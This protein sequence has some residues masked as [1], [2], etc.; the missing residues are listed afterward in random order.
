MFATLAEIKALLGIS[1]T[2]Y[3]TR[4]TALIPMVEI[5]LLEE[6]NNTFT[7]KAISFGGICTITS[8]GSVY[9][10][11]C[12]DGKIDEADFATGDWIWLTG[13]MR[14]DGYYS[15]KSIAAGYIEVN[16]VLTAQADTSTMSL[17]LIDIPSAIKIYFAKMVAWQ[18]YH[19]K[20][21]GLQSESIGNYSYS[22]SALA[23]DAGYPSTL[24]GGLAK[25]KNISLRRGSVF[26]QI[27]DRRGMA[28]GNYA[29]SDMTDL[30]KEVA[31]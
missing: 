27:R 30:Y 17:T 11:N 16:E 1:D 23:S 14:N 29:D 18:L 24:L 15:I 7:N 2:T 28:I 12:A 13:S 25:W 8:A 31:R 19:V 20:D 9:K 3:D 5:D 10:I 26:S 4:I 22:R 21:D 6:C